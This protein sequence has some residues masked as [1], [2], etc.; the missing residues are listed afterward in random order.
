MENKPYFASPKPAKP[1]NLFNWL[2]AAYL[3]ISFLY[4]LYGAIN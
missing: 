3:A 1:D 4:F 2:Y